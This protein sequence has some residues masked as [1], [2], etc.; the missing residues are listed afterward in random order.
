M[1]KIVEIFSDIT[2]KSSSTVVSKLLELDYYNNYEIT[3]LIN[4]D[5]G[6]V[7]SMYSILDAFSI[8][9]SPIKTICIGNAYSAAAVLLAAGNKRYSFPNSR[10]M[11]HGVQSSI[12]EDSQLAFEKHIKEIEKDNLKLYTLLSKL[13]KKSLDKISKDC[14]RDKFFTPEQALK[15]GL[16]DEILKPKEK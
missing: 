11:I 6:D 8:I 12:K 2:L 5:G 10:I 15:Y 1:V 9:E 4:S 16:I 7:E 3:V 14:I 13:T